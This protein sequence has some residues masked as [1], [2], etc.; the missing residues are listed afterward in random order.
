[1]LLLTR[2][3]ESCPHHLCA[4]RASLSCGNCGIVL[5]SRQLFARQNLRPP[6]AAHVNTYPLPL[7]LH[8]VGRSACDLRRDC[9]AY[10]SD[11]DACAVIITQDK[12][13]LEQKMQTPLTYQL[14]IEPA[15]VAIELVVEAA[16]PQRC[17]SC[18]TVRAFGLDSAVRRVGALCTRT[19]VV[20]RS[21]TG[22]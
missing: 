14:T 1:M 5:W 12:R 3:A 17:V 16:T 9:C 6:Q 11:E 21:G 10:S 8:F 2:G 7:G 19:S 18:A 4:K 13:E 22:A 20:D 15:S